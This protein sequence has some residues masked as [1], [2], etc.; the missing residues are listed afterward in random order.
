MCKLAVHN[1]FSNYLAWPNLRLRKLH[2]VSRVSTT[3]L[4]QPLLLQ[5]SWQKMDGKKGC[6]PDTHTARAARAQA[7]TFFGR[8]PDLPHG[9]PLPRALKNK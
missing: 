1:P 7:Y 5:G 9:V 4:R 6:N 2:G 3:A 8:Y